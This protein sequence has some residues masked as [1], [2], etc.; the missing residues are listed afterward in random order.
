M[1]RVLENYDKVFGSEF[2]LKLITGHGEAPKDIRK[3]YDIYTYDKPPNWLNPYSLGYAFFALNSFLKNEETD[4]LIN[5]AHPLPLGVAV[6]VL[7]PKYDMKSIIR[8]TGDI[9]NEHNLSD[10]FFIKWRKKILYEIIL[11][12]LFKRS[13]YV[14][15]VGEKLRNDFLKR[16]YTK[17]QVKNLPQPFDADEFTAPN[18]DKGFVKKELGL[19]PQKF[20]VLYV[21]SLSWIKGG[22][23]LLSVV[24][25]TARK[26]SNDFQF[27]IVGSG[28]YK[29][30]FEDISN[31]LVKVIGYVPP[32]KVLPFYQAADAFIYPTR[33]DGLPNVILE[34]ISSEIPILATPVGEIPYILENTYDFK[35]F[36]NKI[37]ER[38]F[39][40]VNKEKVD[41]LNFNKTK[42][43]Y[44]KLVR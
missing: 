28:T 42:E 24:K 11:P 41:Y 21:G 2:E 1:I 38:D 40:H 22:D 25:E 34:A 32:D 3:S 4:V 20:V 12:R 31:S 8:V 44:L 18:Q 13:D 43:S 35:A 33:S 9:F 27:C 7:A 29:T 37:V 5:I 19:D 36:K 10:N 23:R 17:D 14:I 26:K 30:D 39:E 15:T 6:S 16:G